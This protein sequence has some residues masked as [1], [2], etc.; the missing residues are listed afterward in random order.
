MVYSKREEDYAIVTEL[1]KGEK[2]QKF[3]KELKKWIS[4]S[5]IQYFVKEIF[6][7]KLIPLKTR[8][9]SFSVE[10]AK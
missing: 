4:E 1:I 6:L 2:L 7:W 3:E 8:Q 5:M 10:V 9:K